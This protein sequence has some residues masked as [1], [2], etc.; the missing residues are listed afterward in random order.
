MSTAQSI[1]QDLELALDAAHRAAAAAYL[2]LWR[3]ELAQH[4]LRRHAVSVNGH[5]VLTVGDRTWFE[6]RP[7][8][9]LTDKLF[10]IGALA[11]SLDP[12]LYRHL[13][14]QRIDRPTPEY[15]AETPVE[16][17]TG[18]FTGALTGATQPCQRDFCCDC[19]GTLYAVQWFDASHLQTQVCSSQMRLQGDTLKIGDY[20]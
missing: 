19:A 1:A 3:R 17:V 10:A 9:L 8:T 16:S 7:G 12:S 11:D 18:K 15:A 13:A 4:D 20:L 14:G 6:M 5:G 2:R